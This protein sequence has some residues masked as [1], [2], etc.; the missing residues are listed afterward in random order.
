MIR[1]KGM[2]IRLSGGKACRVSEQ[3]LSDGRRE[4]NQEFSAGL[5]MISAGEG[6]AAFVEV[7]LKEGTLDGACAVSLELDL[8]ETAFL[9]DY[10]HKEYWCSPFFCKNAD[11]IPDQTQALLWKEGDL[12]QYLLPV[13]SAGTHCIQDSHTQNY[14]SKRQPATHGLRYSA[15][16]PNCTCIQ[17]ACLSSSWKIRS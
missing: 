10:R 11:E 8:P 1:I 3:E 7:S 16:H 14:G 17:G 15:H 13:C 2:E 4:E 9:A 12:F 5:S 6:T